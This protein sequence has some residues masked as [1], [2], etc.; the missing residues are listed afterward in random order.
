[1]PEVFDVGVEVVADYGFFDVALGFDDELDEDFCVDL[2]YGNEQKRCST[3]L[4]CRRSAGRRVQPQ[5]PVRS[6]VL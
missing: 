2:V 1:V 3:Y 6:L 5:L 4:A